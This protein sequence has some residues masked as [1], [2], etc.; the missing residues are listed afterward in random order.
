MVQNAGRAKEPTDTALA[1]LQ[2]H[3]IESIEL[4]GVCRSLTRSRSD[5]AKS[6]LRTAV[7]SSPHK[8]VQA[9]ACF[10]LA[11]VLKSSIAQ[12]G[13]DGPAIEKEAESCFQR[14]IKEF[15]DVI[16]Y[17]EKTLGE[18]A[19]GNLY[20]MRNLAIG[21]EAPEIAAQDIAGVAFKLSD[22]RGKVVMLD[23]WG[24]W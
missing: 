3:H 21:K 16:H 7:K 23:F 20:E 13:P 24:H 8:K 19:K 5:A 10:S 18:S 1:L 11:M 2:Q 17:R 4:G 15:G 12:A 9:N 14:V 22:Y 6:F